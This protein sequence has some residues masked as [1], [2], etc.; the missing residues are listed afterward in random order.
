MITFHL[1]FTPKYFTSLY[2]LKTFLIKRFYFY[3]LQ[4]HFYVW[5]IKRSGLIVMCICTYIYNIYV[6]TY[7]CLICSWI[8]N[9]T[10]HFWFTK[11]SLSTWWAYGCMEKH[12]D[13]NVNVSSH[14]RHSFACRTQCAKLGWTRW[15]VTAW[16]LNRKQIP[17]HKIQIK[18]IEYTRDRTKFK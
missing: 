12:Y 10:I 7:F 17:S 9:F 15:R 18:N 5:C 3:I 6:Y 1:T 8:N 2:C 14:K 11:N 16:L 4:S 13:E